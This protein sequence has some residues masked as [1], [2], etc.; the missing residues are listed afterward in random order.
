MARGMGES[1]RRHLDRQDFVMNLF[2]WVSVWNWQSSERVKRDI[3]VSLQDA[4]FPT[5]GEL[6]S[7]SGL[8]HP[9]VPLC[10]PSCKWS[11]FSSCCSV[12]GSRYTQ[13]PSSS[14]WSQVFNWAV[15]AQ[16]FYG[17]DTQTVIDTI[18]DPTWAH[19]NPSIFL[20]ELCDR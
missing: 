9:G 4:T 13:P 16:T 1:S 15:I 17:S 3:L 14:P 5:S 6:A 20:T 11:S 8:A 19:T 7:E 18:G 10:V 2:Y 12:P